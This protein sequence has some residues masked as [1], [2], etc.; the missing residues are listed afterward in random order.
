[1]PRQKEPIN[2]RQRLF[3][4]YIIDGETATNAYLKSGYSK[5]GSIH[6]AGANAS[7]LLKTDRIRTALKDMR[8]ASYLGEAMSLAERRATLA[9]IVRTP[10]SAITPDSPLCVEYSESVDQAGNVTRK[11]KKNS[12][13]E[14]IK[15]DSQLAGELNGELNRQMTNPFLFL[16]SMSQ[17]DRSGDALHQGESVALPATTP[18]PAPETISIDAELVE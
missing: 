2:K 8:E 15:L 12:V 5:S 14:A 17:T 3:L 4:K 6:A 10:L 9:S 1:M 18:G 11:A 16:I 7:R 13:I